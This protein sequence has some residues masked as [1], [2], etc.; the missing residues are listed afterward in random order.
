MK[1]FWLPLLLLL[2]AA[3][4]NAQIV[5]DFDLP[6]FHSISLNTNYNVKIRQFNAQS[7]KA[8]VEQEILDQTDIKVED[9]VLYI[10]PKPQEKG[11]QS[12]W[13]KIDKVKIGPEMTI[14][15]AVVDIKSITV[16]CKG[17]VTSDNTLNT[18]SLRLE[19]NGDGAINVDSK[20][21]KTEIGVFSKGAV[22][23]TGYTS[24]LNAHVTGGGSLLAPQYSSRN[25]TII[26]RGSSY[27]EISSSDNA[28]A[29]LYGPSQLKIG[30]NTKSLTKH[31]HG[32]GSVLRANLP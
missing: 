16:N 2:F 6:E 17:T 9:G 25:G 27:A 31:I 12:V 19:M 3:T 23:L 10:N 7:V 1:R 30:G 4:T 11:K 5:K 22:T 13:A 14:E 21:K 28:T 32:E 26:L 8:T 18:E 20:T 24:D 29:T 15:I